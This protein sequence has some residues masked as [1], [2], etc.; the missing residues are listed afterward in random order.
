MKTTITFKQIDPSETVKEYFEEKAERIAKYDLKAMELHVTLTKDKHL[1][2]AEAVLTAK[3]FRSH[4]EGA[5]E[6]VYASIHDALAKIEKQLQK[7]TTKMKRAR[8]SIS[9]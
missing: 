1:H 2:K 7:R 9:V 3:D 8:T 5:M 4:T 6:D